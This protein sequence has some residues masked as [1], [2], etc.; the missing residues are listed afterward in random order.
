VRTTT[1]TDVIMPLLLRG[2]LAMG[3]LTVSWGVA[4]AQEA[5]AGTRV[6][7]PRPKGWIGLQLEYEMTMDG[8]R[9]LSKS[10]PT[11][12][13]VE[14][15]SPADATGLMAGDVMLEVNGEGLLG[16]SIENVLRDVRPG[17]KLKIVVRREDAGRKVFNLVVGTAPVGWSEE[18]A[19]HMTPAPPVPPPAVMIEPPA[20]PMAGLATARSKSGVVGKVGRNKAT[21]VVG[22]VGPGVIALPLG[23]SGTAAV[24]APWRVLRSS[25]S[26]SYNNVAGAEVVRISEDLGDVIGVEQGILIVN[27]VPG[28]PAAEAGLR[29]GDVIISANGTETLHPIRL[30]QVISAAPN[31]KVK[32]EV[33][34]KKKKETKIISWDAPP[35]E[36]R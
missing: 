36:E 6:R 3:L 7:T 35:P 22:G 14:P 28:S 16:R 1:R 29:D 25:G 15:G 34:R 8:E 31:H 33:I 32:I 4:Q 18:I 24:I 5:R 19:I 17:S 2:V 20:P 26:S 10:Y 9:V 12:I 11:I 23:I 27:V 21:T 13:A 30:V